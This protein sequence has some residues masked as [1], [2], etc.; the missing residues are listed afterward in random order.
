MSEPL[1]LMTGDPE[2]SNRAI[3]A[4]Y[5]SGRV[6]AL[7]LSPS[8]TA[9]AR[10]A[11]WVNAGDGDVSGLRAPF[12]K[13]DLDLV[14]VDGVIVVEDFGDEAG[15]SL[16]L[17]AESAGWWERSDGLIEPPKAVYERVGDATMVD[18]PAVRMALGFEAA[19]MQPTV[20]GKPYGEP[21]LVPDGYGGLI[22]PG[23]VMTKGGSRVLSPEDE[24]ALLGRIDASI[25]EAE[26]DLQAKLRARVIDE[27]YG[28][29]TLERAVYFPAGNSFPAGEPVIRTPASYNPGKPYLW[30]DGLPDSPP[31]REVAWSLWIWG[32]VSLLAIACLIVAILHGAGLLK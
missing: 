7:I 5:K 27:A 19:T 26:A 22:R 4:T 2:R 31:P 1:D 3:D 25:D 20:D 11:R 24:Q 8:S 18:E 10:P 12:A 14:I 32:A 30:V 17:A 28:A 29:S 9:G 13:L 21:L 16:T 6:P 15:L 23:G